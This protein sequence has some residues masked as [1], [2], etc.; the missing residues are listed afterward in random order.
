LDYRAVHSARYVSG[1]WGAVVE[2]GN[3]YAGM[4]S[5]QVAM[6]N[7]GNAMVVWLYSYDN[8]YL[9]TMVFAAGAWG[10]VAL[11][12]DGPGDAWSPQVAM[13]NCGNAMVVWQQ[14]A[15]SHENI[16]IKSVKLT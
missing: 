14:N 2:L 4:S 7:C 11:L 16:Y 10:P 6:D 3:S 9:F 8:H 12:V 13:D 5:V 15:G 1:T